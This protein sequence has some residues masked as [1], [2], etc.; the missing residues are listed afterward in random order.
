M[1]RDERSH[2]M[3]WRREVQDSTKTVLFILQRRK[4][5]TNKQL[6]SLARAK[7]ICVEEFKDYTKSLD[8][9]R[10]YLNEQEVSTLEEATKLT[11]ITK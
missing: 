4:W 11:K 10:T 7:E 6:A 3:Q 1:D 8:E 5:I 9:V 2:A